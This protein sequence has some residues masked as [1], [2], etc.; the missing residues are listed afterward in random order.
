MG[1]KK[2][3]KRKSK[4][5]ALPFRVRWRIACLLHDGATP[6]AILKNEQIQKELAA[7]GQEFTAS[8]LA[9]VKRSAEYREF[10]A[11]RAKTTEAF[12]EIRLSA[13]LLR[14]CDATGAVAE[15]LKLDLLHLIRESINASP[16]D[17]RAI[18]RLVRAAVALSKSVREGQTASLKERIAALMEENLRLRRRLEEKDAASEPKW[19]SEEVADRLSSILGVKDCEEEDPKRE[20]GRN[21]SRR[22]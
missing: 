2:S 11:R 22:A 18:E 3:E 1:E 17:P 9:S 4:F 15:Q 20:P 21:G 19:N 6:G 13:A 12:A 14:D 5:S 10:A 8:Q 16:D 7:L